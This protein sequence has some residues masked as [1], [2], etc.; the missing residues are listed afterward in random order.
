VSRDVALIV[1]PYHLGVERLAVGAGPRALLDA[2]A[3][4]VLGR[5]GRPA[6][7][8]HVRMWDARSRDLDAVVD[9]NRLIARAVR[10]AVEQEMLPVVLAGNC[11]SCVGT[12][13]GLGGGAA[14]GVVWLDAHG[15]FNT[16]ET[17]PSGL[18][19]GMALAA[20]VGL[21]HDDLRIRAG[22][23]DVVAGRNVVMFGVRDLD[24]GEGDRLAMNEVAVRPPDSLEDARDLIVALRQRVER[25]YLHLDID[26]VD[27]RFGLNVETACALVHEAMG[28]LPV[29]AVA[30]TNYNPETDPAGEMRE[31]ALALLRSVAE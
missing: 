7:V 2:G 23:H 26:A 6:Q 17:S 12:L 13:A 31:A 20:A 28:N 29:A 27:A 16:P 14:A 5:R 1:A 18:L 11:N 4:G 3:D 21:C 10:E 15:D 8:E 25:V 19:E 30:L 24:P 9:V 22:L